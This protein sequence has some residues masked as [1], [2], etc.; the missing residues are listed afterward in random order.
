MCNEKKSAERKHLLDALMQTLRHDGCCP[1]NTDRPSSMKTLDQREEELTQI[2]E[3]IKRE[4][5]EVRRS[6]NKLVAINTLP[7]EL[8]GFIFNLVVNSAPKSFES[9]V[10]K[11]PFTDSL[12]QLDISGPAAR[13]LDYDFH[14]AMTLSN[15]CRHWRE[16][17]MASARL[18]STIYPSRSKLVPMLIDRSKEAG[19]DVV[20]IARQDASHAS[21]FPATATKASIPYWPEPLTNYL[22]Q[23]IVQLDERQ[24]KQWAATLASS[25]APHLETL[26]I[27]V[28]R[29]ANVIQSEPLFNGVTPRLRSLTLSGF[30]VPW[31]SNIFTDLRDLTLRQHKTIH[32]PTM[33][34]FL[35]LLGRNPGLRRLALELSG[36]QAPPAD[37]EHTANNVTLPKLANVVLHDIPPH[38]VALLVHHTTF[39]SSTQ[40]SISHGPHT[41]HAVDT[42]VLS[43]FTRFRTPLLRAREMRLLPWNIG[44]DK[45]G[46]A[47]TSGRGL[48]EMHVH[49]DLA[50]VKDVVDGIVRTP[51][52]YVDTLVMENLSISDPALVVGLLRHMHTVQTLSVIDCTFDAVVIRALVGED[53]LPDLRNLTLSGHEVN[54]ADIRGLIDS[55]KSNPSNLQHISVRN[56][57][58]L[59]RDFV[60]WVE[61]GAWRS[62]A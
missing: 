38:V 25:T 43:M 1:K 54:E 60:Q 2:E 29:H 37:F 13:T 41:L 49:P 23:L 14:Y 26:C 10:Q 51:L 11:W 24:M 15:V 20:L 39:P 56:C 57:T 17:S 47:Y 33:H 9:A 18:W 8:L 55:R 12:P 40:L 7:A 4:L 53:L 5:C 32:R 58:G 16:V 28:T 48:L 36:P 22:R 42:H 27:S 3:M 62:L 45:P 21:K 59:S 31:D 35:T 34:E 61:S 6:R 46:A 19:F 50:R 30:V 44:T 52:R